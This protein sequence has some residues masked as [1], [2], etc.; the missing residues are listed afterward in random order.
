LF[1]IHY[2]AHSWVSD[3]NHGN[4]HFLRGLAR[5]L[6]K[7]GEKVRCYE[8]LGSWSLTN[9]IKQEDQRAISAI[10]DFCKAYPELKVQFYQNDARLGEWLA[11]ELRGADIVILHEWNHPR[12][13]N[14]VLG[15]KSKLG[16]R[17]L[18]H[19][20]HHRT[21]TSPREILQFN[22][23]LFDGV[24]AFGEAIRSI[25]AN[26][27]G[28][29]RVWTFHEAADVQTFRPMPSEKNMDALWIGNWGEGERTRE[30]EEFLVRPAQQL[31]GLKFVAYG[32]RYPEA[33]LAQLLRANI[34]FRGYLPNLKSA[35]AYNQAKIALHIPRRQYSNGL[36]GIPTIRMFE[37]LACGAF[38]LCSPWQDDE[39]LF[40]PQQDYLCA[41]SGAA[42]QA[43]LQEMSRDERA[44]SQIA[45]SG[46]NTILQ[47]HTCAHRAAELIE[48]CQE[49]G[50]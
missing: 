44:R 14:H 40:R 47:R 9:L 49:L 26:G 36:G 13:V 11:R 23:H 46:L 24:L 2:F 43:I 38:L 1:D 7:A 21:Y 50:R 8:E 39:G 30:L 5:A 37:A 34:E 4:A 15:L 28:M 42:M 6:L 3:W 18:L 31:T 27:F 16:F 25:Y 19:D 10:D 35:E 48:I 45:G 41:S 29:E 22:L 20:T 33:A 12:L 17:V 32:V